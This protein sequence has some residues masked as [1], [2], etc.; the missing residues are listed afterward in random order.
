MIIMEINTKICTAV[1]ALLTAK[2]SF[3]FVCY[4]HKTNHIEN[5]H[6]QQK[7]ASLLHILSGAYRI[8]PCGLCGENSNF[9]RI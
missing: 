2:S 5:E 9:R 4:T 8:L 6:Q 3:R 7:G 1:Y